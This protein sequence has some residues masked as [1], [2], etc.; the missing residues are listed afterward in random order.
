MKAAWPRLGDPRRARAAVALVRLGSDKEVWKLLE[1]S[2]DPE[3]RSNFI[4]ALAPYGADPSILAVELERLGEDVGAVSEKN[5]YLF[6]PLIS[7]QRALIQA[8]AAYPKTALGPEEP[9]RLIQTLIKL[10]RNDPDGGVHSS[11]ELVLRRWGYVDRLNLEPGQPP[12][13]G[14]AIRRRWYVNR[15][16]QTMVLI[17]GPA[18]FDMGSPRSEP[19]R[20]DFKPFHRRLIPRRFAIA[21]REVNV[22]SFQ[23]YTMETHKRRH[24]YEVQYS[25]TPDCPQPNMT[26]YEAAAYCN[27]LGAKEK[28]RPCY[29]PNDKGQY[30]AGM[31]VDAEAVA[32][33]GYR[34]PTQAEWEY[35]CRAGTVTSRYFGSPPGLLSYYEWYLDNAG[36]KGGHRTRPCGSLLPNDLGLFDLLGNVIEWCHDRQSES[37]IIPG[38]MIADEILGETVLRENRILRGSS[39]RRASLGLRSANQAWAEA[40]AFEPDVGMR[41]ARTIP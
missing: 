37:A 17:D 14:E 25:P 40:A 26:W 38:R 20:G 4:T 32:A 28:L 29:L 31:R 7:R 5:S 35:A 34:L 8:L 12:R 16:G 36:V 6:D 19:T 27:W 10:Y 30:A 39:F 3:V 41:V 21:S 1:H 11:A 13:A 2:K 15:E 33:G 22:E 24:G 9:S 23:T 18:L